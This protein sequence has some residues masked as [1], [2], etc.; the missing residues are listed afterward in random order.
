ML[1]TSLVL[2]GLVAGAFLTAGAI[3]ALC[4][5]V[6]KSSALS[7]MIGTLAIPALICA[8]LIYWLMTMEVD[9]APPGMVIIGNL[10]AIAVITPL[11]LLA[12]RLTTRF[13]D[14]RALRNGS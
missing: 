2:V 10:T 9:D 14:R 1:V 5:L 6:T 4:R 3:A 12:S 11:A 7:L 13:F 8:S